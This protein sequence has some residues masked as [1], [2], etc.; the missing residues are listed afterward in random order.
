MRVPSRLGEAN[1][2][3]LICIQCL[4]HLKNEYFFIVYPGLRRMVLLFWL[5]RNP[6]SLTT[7]FRW[8][9]DINLYF[10]RVFNKPYFFK[11]VSDLQKTWKDGT[12]NFHMPCIQSPLLLTYY[13]TL[14]IMK[15][16]NTDTLLTKLLGL[17]RFP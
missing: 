1:P 16:I 9:N 2:E 10:F 12:V 11:N 13:G 6:F 14:A 7:S 3:V 4:V 17:F 15:K 8:A 5:C